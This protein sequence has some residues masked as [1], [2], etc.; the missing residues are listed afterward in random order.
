MSYIGVNTKHET[1]NAG[2]T[3]TNI[4]DFKATILLFFLS[5]F[6]FTNTHAYRTV[7]EEVGYLFNSFLPLPSTSQIYRTLLQRAHLCT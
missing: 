6:S 2:I 7:G 1:C 3:E 4:W 5:E